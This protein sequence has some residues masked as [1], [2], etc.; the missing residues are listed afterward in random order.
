MQYSAGR[1]M[2]LFDLYSPEINAIHFFITKCCK[3]Y[4]CYCSDS[5]KLWFLSRYDDLVQ[6]TRDWETF[7]SS[8]GNMIACAR[9][10]KRPFEKGPRASGRTDT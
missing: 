9:S 7:S 3:K 10:A 5:A 8:E 1:V 2:E 4:P 6:T